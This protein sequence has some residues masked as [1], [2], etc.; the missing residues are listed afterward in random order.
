MVRTQD[1]D[2]FSSIIMGIFVKPVDSHPFL[3]LLAPQPFVLT[4]NYA[5][6]PNP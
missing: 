3:P 4:F 5:T 1:F 6:R 2:S